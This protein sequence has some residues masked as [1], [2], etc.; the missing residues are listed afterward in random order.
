MNIREDCNGR[1]CPGGGLA[2]TG[3]GIHREDS[4]AGGRGGSR[5]NAF[6]AA[7]SYNN[8]NHRYRDFQRILI[9]YQPHGGLWYF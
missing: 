9:I 6:K 4:S 5:Q 1:G 8:D 2:Q 7:A 3:R